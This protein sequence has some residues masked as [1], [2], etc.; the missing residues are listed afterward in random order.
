MEKQNAKIHLF[1]LLSAERASS[2]DLL[3]C[4]SEQVDSSSFAPSD[5]TGID[6]WH[7]IFFHTDKGPF[8]C[9]QASAANHK[10]HDNI[11]N[12]L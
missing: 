3:I 5:V 6:M 8:S 4:I 10:N 11:T 1:Y 2:E 7:K 12:I 9:L